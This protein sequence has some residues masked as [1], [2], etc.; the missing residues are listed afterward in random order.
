MRNIILIMAACAL[1]NS[2]RA[3]KIVEKH[4]DFTSKKG[5]ALNLQITDSILI[6]TWKKNEVFAKA[7]VN[8]NDNKDNDVYETIF[9]E[10]GNRVQIKADFRSG[11]FNGK[12]NCCES[13]IAWAIYLPENTEVS[14]ETINGNITIS[15]VT[16]KIKAHTISG[17]IDVGVP[18]GKKADLEFKTISGNIYTNHDIALDGEKAMVGEEISKKI[19]GGGVPINLETI[20]GNIYFRRSN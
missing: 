11:Y 10:S 8:I 18:A 16:S 1:L 15:G 2:A 20:S 3:Q 4:I 19:N 12:K 17:F 13:R 7:S 6:R 5:V 14:V 9:D